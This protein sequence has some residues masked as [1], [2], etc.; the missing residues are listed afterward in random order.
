L[1]PNYGIGWN[2]K[3]NVVFAAKILPKGL[4]DRAGMKV[5]DILVNVKGDKPRSVERAVELMSKV[6]YG[7]ECNLVLRRGK[8]QIA[9]KMKA[10]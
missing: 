8:D 6:N 2:E 10:D 4:A 9:V 7:E 3:A 1:I 5:G